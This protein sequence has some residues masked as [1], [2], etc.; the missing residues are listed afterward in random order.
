MFFAFVTH[1][2][3]WMII[4]SFFGGLYQIA[5]AASTIAYKKNQQIK[6]SFGY[7]D[8]GYNGLFTIL[9]SI[10]ATLYVKSWR[11]TQ[12]TLALIWECKTR[13]PDIIKASKREKA[14]TTAIINRVSGVVEEKKFRPSLIFIIILNVLFFI[15]GFA[16]NVGVF[17]LFNNLILLLAKEL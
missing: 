8:P 13:M 15:F 6:I 1:M 14:I 10:W 7:H 5:S 2:V 3:G 11:R 9:I 17:F 4:P 16:I 12:S